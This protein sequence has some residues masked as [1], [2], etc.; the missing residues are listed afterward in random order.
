MNDRVGFQIMLSQ[1]IY[2]QAYGR[3]RRRRSLV[4]N[5]IN[6]INTTL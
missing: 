2:C 1:V 4:Y 5:N 6:N 3:Q